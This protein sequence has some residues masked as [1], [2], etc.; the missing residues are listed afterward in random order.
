MFPGKKDAVVDMR[1]ELER[2]IYE[3]TIVDGDILRKF[4]IPET[5]RRRKLL[6]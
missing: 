4:R 1:K 5:V 6:V 3:D 2:H